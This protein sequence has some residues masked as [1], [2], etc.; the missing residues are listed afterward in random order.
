MERHRL[1]TLYGESNQ[2]SMPWKR[3]KSRHISGTPM[4]REC[5]NWSGANTNLDSFTNNTVRSMSH[6]SFDWLRFR[7]FCSLSGFSWPWKWEKGKER[8]AGKMRDKATAWINLSLV[9]VREIKTATGAAAGNWDSLA[10][11]SAVRREMHLPVATCDACHMLLICNCDENLHMP[12]TRGFQSFGVLIMKL[13]V[14]LKA[15]TL[16]SQ[17]LC[18]SPSSGTLGLEQQMPRAKQ[19]TMKLKMPPTT[20]T[21]I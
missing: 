14:P 10:T 17:P 3:S 11:G 4:H 1:H 7:T 19:L 21:T 6:F 13:N 8:D 2:S 9:N 18:H 5:S 12:P 20:T 15:N 16:L